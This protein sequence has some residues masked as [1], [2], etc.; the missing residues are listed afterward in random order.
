MSSWKAHL[1]VLGVL[2]AVVAA[3]S[4][5]D[6]TREVRDEQGVVA[7]FVA[8]GFVL[9]AAITTGVTAIFRLDLRGVVAVHLVPVCVALAVAGSWYTKQRRAP[10][11]LVTAQPAAPPQPPEAPAFKPTPITPGA[12]RI[13]LGEFPPPKS[14]K[15]RVNVALGSP[16]YESQIIDGA[17][18]AAYVRS[19]RGALQLCLE[20]YEETPSGSVVIRFKITPAG[21]STAIEVEKATAKSETALSCIKTVLRGWVFPFK[22]PNETPVM[23]PLKYEADQVGVTEQPSVGLADA[24]TLFKCGVQ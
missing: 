7:W 15:R 6:L 18:L 9:Y 10:V 4:Y 1:T 22:P 8:M 24:G 21:R 20:R 16:G 11:E 13:G 5:V 17:K 12:E 2:V 19:R 23:L 14:T 3:V